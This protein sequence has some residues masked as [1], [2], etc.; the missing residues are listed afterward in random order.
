VRSCH[1]CQ[2]VKPGPGKWKQRL[3]Q[4]R[5]GAPRERV[6]IDLIGPLPPSRRGKKYLVVMQDC[7]SKWV[8][9]DAIAIK[10]TTVV[11]QQFLPHIKKLNLA[12][13]IRI[14]LTKAIEWLKSWKHINLAHLNLDAVNRLASGGAIIYNNTL[15]NLGNLSTLSL[16]RNF[17]KNVDIFFVS[18]I[19][20]IRYLSLAANT[21]TGQGDFNAIEANAFLMQIKLPL[22]TLDLSNVGSNVRLSSYCKNNF[23]SFDAWFWKPP[24]LPLT[25]YNQSDSYS[26]FGFQ[27]LRNVDQT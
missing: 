5:V 7:F 3:K 16:R 21:F 26:L 9:V 2:L 23:D 25:P 8:E 1:H 15:C 20:N 24:I 4:E 17:I 11:A 13:N 19:P 22:E 12:C 18:F 10:K 6:A 27:H 14:G